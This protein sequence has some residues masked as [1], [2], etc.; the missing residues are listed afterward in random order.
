MAWIASA[1]DPGRGWLALG[2]GSLAASAWRPAQPP[3]ASGRRPRD[4]AARS[5]LVD[6]DGRAGRPAAAEGQVERGLLR[7]HLLP[8]RLPDHPDRRS[9]RPGGAWGRR[10]KDVQVVFITVDPARD[11]PAA[12]EDLSLQ[13]GLPEGRHRPDRHA[14]ADRRRRPRPTRSTTRRQGTGANYT[15]DHSTAIYLM[16]PNGQFRQRH[17]RRP[18]ARPGRPTQIAEAMSGGS[19]R[20]LTATA[21][22]CD[23][24]DVLHDTLHRILLQAHNERGYDALRPARGGLSRRRRRC[25]WRRRAARDFWRSPLNP[26]GDTDVGPHALRLAPTCS[27]T[28]P[29]A[30]ASRPG[31]STASRSSGDAGRGARGRGLVDRPG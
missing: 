19:S 3:R 28:S 25:G 8:G 7:L 13:P 23:P 11:T 27:P 24:L 22:A 26:A 30:T 6:Q 20:E 4:P 9:A 29:A 12:A 10:R 1:G 21:D 18:D 16:D 17:R 15:V 5:S 31:A 2:A 14:G